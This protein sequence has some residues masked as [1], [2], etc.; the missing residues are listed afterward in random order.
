MVDILIIFL[1]L[2]IFSRGAMLYL[3]IKKDVY[4]GFGFS[5]FGDWMVIDLIT[6][7]LL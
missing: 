6:R 3:N 5:W 2:A 1:V 7:L 4:L